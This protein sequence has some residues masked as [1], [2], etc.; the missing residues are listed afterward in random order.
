MIEKVTI[1]NFQSHKSSTLNLSPNVNVIIGSSDSGKSSIAR[2]IGW[3]LFNRPLGFSF[4]SHFSKKNEPVEV[5]IKFN[6]GVLL[7]KK[8]HDQNLY[9]VN[10]ERL[11]TIGADVPIKVL[12]LHRLGKINYQSQFEKIFL[13]QDSPSEI[14][15]KI[16]EILGIDLADELLKYI[17]SSIFETRKE[18]KLKESEI[19]KLK[20]EKDSYKYLDDLSRIIENLK[21]NLNKYNVLVEKYRR[22]ISLVSLIGSILEEYKKVLGL[23]KYSKQLERIKNNLEEYKKVQERYSKLDK[24]IVSLHEI[25][26]E[27]DKISISDSFIEKFTRTSS[28]IDELKRISEI[29]ETCSSILSKVKVLNRKILES[30]EELKDLKKRYIDLLK[31]AKVCPLCG[32]IITE[33]DLERYIRL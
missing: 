1:K 4:K 11:E 24:I 12:E 23:L 28:K 26:Y 32:Q 22:L 8:S 27:L 7:R 20:K 10:D 33:G 25:E 15:K 2:A 31:E 9:C 18:I 29:W 5:E 19:E 6:D 17:N 21:L 30:A 16:N 13:L 14:S 3:A